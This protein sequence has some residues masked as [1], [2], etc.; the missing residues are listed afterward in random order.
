MKAVSMLLA[1]AQYAYFLV[2]LCRIFCHFKYISLLDAQSMRRLYPAFVDAMLRCNRGYGKK[3]FHWRDMAACR[4]STAVYS[5]GS[6]AAATLTATKRDLRSRPLAPLRS[7]PRKKSSEKL[8]YQIMKTCRIC[9]RASRPA[10]KVT[11]RGYS[12]AGHACVVRPPPGTWPPRSG[13]P[14]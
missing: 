1:A 8:T 14:A 4:G 10:A 2:Y 12:R 13:L 5:N 6:A 3:V 9:G 7:V 11:G